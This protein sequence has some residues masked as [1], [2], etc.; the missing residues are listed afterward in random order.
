MLHLRS[1]AQA[2]SIAVTFNRCVLS[3]VLYKYYANSICLHSTILLY[4]LLLR[5]MYNVHTIL[6]KNRLLG[7]IF[8][9]DILDTEFIDNQSGVAGGD[10]NVYPHSPRPIMSAVAVSPY[11][12]TRR[13]SVFVLQQ[14]NTTG[15][16][17]HHV[18]YCNS[19]A[20]SMHHIITVHYLAQLSGTFDQMGPSTTL[21]P[22]PC[23]PARPSPSPGRGRT[24]WRPPT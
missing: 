22:C 17:V 23:S 4:F 3:S 14:L 16:V 24:S 8:S 9:Y 6:L 11:T 5:V 18:N 1:C 20:T 7:L 13:T 12:A 19:Q 21:P 10:A 2:E 15:D